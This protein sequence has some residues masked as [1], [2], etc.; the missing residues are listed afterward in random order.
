MSEIRTDTISAANGTDPVTLTKQ[1][2]LK[3]WLCLKQTDNTIRDSFGISSQTDDGSGTNTVTFTSAFDDADGYAFQGTSEDG[4]GFNDV[5]LCRRDNS[6]VR[7][8]TQHGFY[9][10]HGNPA[11]VNDADYANTYYVGDLA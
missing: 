5:A 1:M 11:V 8:A 9:C 4:G 10:T 6:Q 3:A 7:S 2:A